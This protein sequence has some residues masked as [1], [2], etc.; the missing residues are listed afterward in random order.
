MDL[1]VVL[2]INTFRPVINVGGWRFLSTLGL[3]E[4]QE[5]TTEVAV[6][7]RSGAAVDVTVML[8]VMLV[9][10]VVIGIGMDVV[11]CFA[12]CN[13]RCDTSMR[14]SIS[15]RLLCITNFDG[16]PTTVDAD[17][18]SFNHGFKANHFPHD[19]SLTKRYQT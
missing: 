19:S 8:L 12:V 11:V 17:V 9:L 14:R 16:L 1:L 13:S 2:R 7:G 10:V 4:N 3:L 5:D 18:G 6:D 15:F